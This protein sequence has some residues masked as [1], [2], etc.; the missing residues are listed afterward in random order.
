M[1]GPDDHQPHVDRAIS[2]ARGTEPGPPPG[3]AASVMR[4]VR[5][6]ESGFSLYRRWRRSRAAG[7]ANF[8]AS[9]GVDRA[10]NQHSTAGRLAQEGVAVT[11]KVLWGVATVGAVA[12]IA[13]F[14]FGVP[15]VG[16][17]TEGTVGG[18]KRATI[19]QS[20]NIDLGNMDV[21]QFLQSDTFDRL[22]R[23][24]ATRSILEK[25]ARNQELRNALTSSAI[26]AAMSEE[27]FRS[28]VSEPA[29]EELL[30]R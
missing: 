29:F 15:Q 2:E 14:Y 1:N 16:P 24:D 19:A 21:Q 18:A 3:F 8:A 5:Q 12:M 28:A 7:A 9:H 23:N 25:A 27:A 4:R 22:M 11:R 13:M 17:G 30:A 26:R 20:G 6:A 10:A